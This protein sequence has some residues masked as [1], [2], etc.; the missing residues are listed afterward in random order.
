MYVLVMGDLET[1]ERH[2]VEGPRAESYLEEANMLNLD[3]RNHL[4]KLGLPRRYI[5]YTE[6]AKP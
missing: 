4:R 3:V 5:W 6:E 1:R 2:M